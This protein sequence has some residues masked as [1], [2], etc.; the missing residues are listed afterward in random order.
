MSNDIP[1]F[2]TICLAVNGDKEALSRVVKCYE[3]YLNEMCT[4]KYTDEKGNVT[5]VFDNELKLDLKN[6]LI[7]AITKFII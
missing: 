3:R 7:N 2:E 6:K 4:Q 1:N 5:I